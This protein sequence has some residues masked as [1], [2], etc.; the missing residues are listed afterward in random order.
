M[1]G[2][3]VKASSL[4]NSQIGLLH[5]DYRSAGQVNMQAHIARLC[6]DFLDEEGI[7]TFEWLARSPDLNQI[8]HCWNMLSRHVKHCTLGLPSMHY[9]HQ[10]LLVELDSPYHT[11]FPVTGMVER[12]FSF[13]VSKG[14]PPLLETRQPITAN[15][16]TAS[17]GILTAEIEDVETVLAYLIEKISQTRLPNQKATLQSKGFFDDGTGTNL[18]WRD[19]DDE[20]FSICKNR[21][22]IFPVS[23]SQPSS[24]LNHAHSATCSCP[25]RPCETPVVTKSTQTEPLVPKVS[26]DNCLPNCMCQSDNVQEKTYLRA[27]SEEMPKRTTEISNNT[28]ERE[29]NV[30]PHISFVHRNRSFSFPSAEGRSNLSY[31]E[32]RICPKDLDCNKTSKQYSQKSKNLQPVSTELDVLRWIQHSEEDSKPFNKEVRFSEYIKGSSGLVCAI[33]KQLERRSKVNVVKKTENA[34]K[35]KRKKRNGISRN[36]NFTPKFM[37]MLETESDRARDG[38][39]SEDTDLIC[40]NVIISPT[41]SNDSAFPSVSDSFLRYLGLH[42]ESPH[43]N[44]HFSEQEIE[45]KCGSLLLAFKIDKL[46][47]SKRLQL[48]RK[49]RNIAEK[50]VENAIQ[51]LK[52]SLNILNLLSTDHQV[53]DLIMRMFQQIKILQQSSSKVSSRAEIYGAVQQVLSFFSNPFTVFLY[54]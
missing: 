52:A 30:P 1:A 16:I 13:R 51:T 36:K 44:E 15:E 53:R 11:P 18:Y 48:Q 3:H 25:T 47:L 42:K 4:H 24:P 50:S 19:P 54:L 29:K 6:M 22:R 20:H 23:T 12:G 2:D 35:E 39:E 46:T 7:K 45:S 43:R 32:D 17:L 10:I 38:M 33:I 31:G 26:C 28:H 40:S 21:N 27:S 5:H 9:P 49:K 37:E 8:E 34:R 41:V 14:S